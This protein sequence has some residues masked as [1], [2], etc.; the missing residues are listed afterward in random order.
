MDYPSHSFLGNFIQLIQLWAAI[1]VLFF[2]QRLLE[3]SPILNKLIELDK[4]FKNFIGSHQDVAT[5]NKSNQEFI[6]DPTKWNDFVPRIR[7]M[8]AMTFFYCVFLLF[9]IGI[10]RS[11]EDFYP[12]KHPSF[13]ICSNI[14]I[15][16]YVIVCSLK[17]H[18]MFQKYWAPVLYIIAILVFFISYKFLHNAIKWFFNYAH[19][20]TWVLG[21][22]TVGLTVVTLFFLYKILRSKTDRQLFHQKKLYII[23]I[24]IA[25]VFYKFLSKAIEWFNN[26]KLEHENTWFWVTIGTLV[27][28]IL[29]MLV[30][31]LR[32]WGNNLVVK[33]K[34]STLKR[35]NREF[36]HLKGII[37]DII[38]LGS[39]NDLSD[40][41]KE[42]VKPFLSVD[43]ILFKSK[44]HLIIKELR[45]NHFLE[46]TNKWA[47]EDLNN[48]E[49]YD[50]LE[51]NTK[52]LIFPICYRHNLYRM[53]A[54]QLMIKITS[55]MRN[56]YHKEKFEE[57]LF[58]L[59]NSP[60]SV[61]N[62]VLKNEVTLVN[63]ES[64]ANQQSTKDEI[65][66]EQTKSK[67]N[68]KSQ[69]GKDNSRHSSKKKIKDILSKNINKEKTVK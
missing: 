7:N 49:C 24:L 4:I 3:V 26:V 20:H 6:Y 45:K 16:I 65:N 60:N 25:V 19:M 40:S 35:L 18:R 58:P 31:M 17:D 37:N 68:K 28:C 27:V 12:V 64:S 15:I 5:F 22:V 59:K 61:S 2:Y 39:F 69:E 30:L 14:L 48:K 41:A 23:A 9:Y 52:K 47:I 53:D 34:V 1:C 32:I 21:C 38:K 55:K 42:I 63:S 29:A 66:K 43:E 44:K 62:E 8:A 57:A 46:E 51:C 54:S 11:L 50:V 36:N 13:L 10:E 56:D 33:R 67:N